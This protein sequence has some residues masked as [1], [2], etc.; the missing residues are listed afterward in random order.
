[1]KT[2]QMGELAKLASSFIPFV[3]YLSIAILIIIIISSLM[4]KKSAYI[5]GIIF[6]FVH[7]YLIS[8]LLVMR[9]SQGMGF[10]VVI[11]SSLGMIVFSYICYKEKLN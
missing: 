1:M 7:L 4:K 5:A 11:P 3:V 6:G 9:V 10:I 2:Q 8:V